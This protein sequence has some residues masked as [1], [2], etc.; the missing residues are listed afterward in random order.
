MGGIIRL[1]PTAT[2]SAKKVKKTCEKHLTSKL[3]C[4]IILIER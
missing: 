4:V 3:K 2:A 1:K